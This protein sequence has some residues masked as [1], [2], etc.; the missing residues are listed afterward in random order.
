ML[1]DH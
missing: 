1:R